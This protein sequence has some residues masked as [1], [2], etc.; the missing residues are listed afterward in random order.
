[1]VIT[2]RKSKDCD[3]TRRRSKPTPLVEADYEMN[4]LK[5]R[6]KNLRDRASEL[7]NERDSALSLLREKHSHSR[8]S[9]PNG[10]PRKLSY[11]K[12]ALVYR[13]KRRRDNSGRPRSRE[14]KSAL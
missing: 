11:S 13:I 5:E 12:L 10:S 7:E 2:S 3:Q 9:T 1:M 6:D 4:D 14:N 8:Q